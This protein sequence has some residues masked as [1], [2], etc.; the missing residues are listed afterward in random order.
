MRQTEIFLK[1]YFEQSS[2]ECLALHGLIEVVVKV[3]EGIFAGG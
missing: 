3:S 1:A 2:Q